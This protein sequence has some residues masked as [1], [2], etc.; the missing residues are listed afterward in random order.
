MWHSLAVSTDEA[1]FDMVTSPITT[2]HFHSRVLALLSSSLA[3]PSQDV[4]GITSASSQFTPLRLSA[5]SAADTALTPDE[6]VSQ[7]I[8]ITSSWIDLC[9]PDP[10]IAD[11]SSQ[12][13][14]LEIA[15][16]AF[17]GVM[18]VIIPGPRFLGTNSGEDM[19][20]HY[21][22]AVLDALALG[23]FMQIYLWLPMIAQPDKTAQKMGDLAPFA[24][25][26]YLNNDAR[27]DLTLDIFGSWAAWD[28]IRAMCKYSSRLGVGKFNDFLILHS[29][30]P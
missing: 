30:F 12:I 11:L 15:Y 21:S 25:E 7:V 24:R 14:K 9:S 29:W 8:A 6:S 10:L 4:D 17:C 28:I 22:R 13:L 27:V 3:R 23:P 20:V 2:A 26:E 5:L 16:A 18:N 19:L 1:Q